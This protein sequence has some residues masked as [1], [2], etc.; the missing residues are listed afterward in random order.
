MIE[1]VEPDPE[2]VQRY[3]RH[4]GVVCIYTNDAFDETDILRVHAAIRALGIGGTI[5]YK[6]NEA[7]RSFMY[8][9]FGVSERSQYV[10]FD[11][12]AE[13]GGIVVQRHISGE[14]YRVVARL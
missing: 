12:S 5:P 8:Q 10:S 7:S 1:L 11:N 2:V 4:R 13:H 3:G 9:M 6:T 14:R